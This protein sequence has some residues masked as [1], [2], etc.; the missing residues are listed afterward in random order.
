MKI[1]LGAEGFHK[2]GALYIPTTNSDHM[3]NVRVYDSADKLLLLDA[4]I[5]RLAKAAV[6]VSTAKKLDI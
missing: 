3:I 2:N 1:E 6:K 5:T 4:R